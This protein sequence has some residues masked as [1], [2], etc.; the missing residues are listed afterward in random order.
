M[1]GRS[2]ALGRCG[3]AEKGGVIRRRGATRRG[4]AR[5]K[6]G[7]VRGVLGTLRNRIGK[8]EGFGNQPNVS[9]AAARIS[10]RIA[11]A[12]RRSTVPEL[13]RTRG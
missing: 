2:V 7:S 6:L 5:R 4:T 1:A 8:K 12:A 3:P 13:G 11:T 9:A 10:P